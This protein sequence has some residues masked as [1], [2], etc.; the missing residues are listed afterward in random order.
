MSNP[1]KL[2][3][4]LIEAALVLRYYIVF[5]KEIRWSD[6]QYILENEFIGARIKFIP[7]FVIRYCVNHFE[8]VN[9]NA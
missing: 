6:V 3:Y 9:K 7:R 1:K 5:L 2:Q 8:M 4:N